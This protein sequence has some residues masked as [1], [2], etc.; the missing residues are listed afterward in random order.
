MSGATVTLIIVLVVIVVVALLLVVALGPRRR[1][2]QLQQR[3]GPEYER[4]VEESPNRREAERELLDRKQ[5]HD[6]LQ[7]RELSDPEKQRYG[8]QWGH[9]QEQ[10]VDDPPGALDAA[11][12][13]VTQVMTDRG[14]PSESY[15]Q[16]LSDLSV[17]HARPLEH[18]RAAHD[19]AAH[20]NGGAVSTEDLRTAIVHYRALFAE[21]LD[22]APAGNPRNN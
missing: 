10:F 5:R 7:L 3:F 1:S 17:E 14:Y 12:R 20:A 8:A 13:L 2:R 4:A 18:F 19:I 6:K 9:I 16:Q 22:G 11:D 15:D 21:L